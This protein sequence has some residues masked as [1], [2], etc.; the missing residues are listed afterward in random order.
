MRIQATLLG[1]LLAGLPPLATATEKLVPARLDAPALAVPVAVLAAAPTLDGSFADWPDG[2]WVAVPV[3]PAVEN[4]SQNRAGRLDVQLRAGVHGDRVYL[5]ARWPDPRAD[6]EFKP[7]EWDGTR[8]RRGK[9]VD[10]MFAVRFDLDGDYDSCMLSDRDYRVDA[11]LWSAGRS[12]P[13]GYADDTWQLITTRFQEQAAEYEGPSGKTVYIKKSRDDGE[14]IYENT[15]P[16]RNKFAGDR[17]PGIEQLPSPA[18]SVADVSAKGAW[19]DGHWQLE[20]SRKLDTGHA[21]DAVLAK[22]KQRRGAIGV[23]ERGSAEHKSVSGELLF[24]FGAL[25]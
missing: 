22:G 13:A 1:A 9:Q 15:R 7:W 5:A 21:D 3:V 14:P 24:D 8:Y 2:G 23:F 18:G 19:V 16:D 12:D 17:L 25:R 11:W 4:D 20:L 10:D 6:T